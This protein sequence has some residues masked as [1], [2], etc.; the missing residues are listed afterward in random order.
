MAKNGESA[1]PAAAAAPKSDGGGGGGGKKEKNKGKQKGDG[2]GGA[3]REQGNHMEE[4]VATALKGGE[5]PV[6]YFDEND[7]LDLEEVSH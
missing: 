5:R 2:G 7:G 6:I 1:A 4:G 3:V